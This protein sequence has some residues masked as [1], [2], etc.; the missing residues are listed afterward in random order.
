M[1]HA[2][3]FDSHPVEIRASFVDASGARH[4]LSVLRLWAASDLAAIGVFP[5]VDTPV[6]D[7]YRSTGSSLQWD[8]ETV[9]RVHTVEPVPPVDLAALKRELRA[10]IDA[11]AEVERSRYITP[12]AGQALTY[13]GKAAE[14]ERYIQTSGAGD[15]PLLAAEVG[16]TGETLQQ[17]AQIVANLHAQW[18]MI[19]GA[20]ERARLTAKAAV[21]AA[22]D[23]AAARGVM[24]NWPAP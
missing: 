14:A 3:L 13:Q 20:I 10:G 5:V 16:V 21:D 18:Q 8:G 19:G 11:A 15:Y 7:G 9:T 4:P 12:G 6:P 23:E 22:E 1:S 17:V 2:I 24:P